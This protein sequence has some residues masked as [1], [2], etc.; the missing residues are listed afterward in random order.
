V[1]VPLSG[2]GQTVFRPDTS[3]KTRVAVKVNVAAFLD[4]FVDRVTRGLGGLR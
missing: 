4:L 2:P 3:S 1:E